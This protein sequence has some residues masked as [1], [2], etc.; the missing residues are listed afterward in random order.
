[1]Y[2]IGVYSLSTDCWKIIYFD[3][4]Y[5]T[6]KLLSDPSSKCVNGV[7]YFVKY[8]GRLVCFDLHNEKIREVNF[9]KNC[10]YGLLEIGSIWR[11]SSCGSYC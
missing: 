4:D 8:K 2:R 9:P 6:F 10:N 3:S 1:M 7:A 5:G 11:N